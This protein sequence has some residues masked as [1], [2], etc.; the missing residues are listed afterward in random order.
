MELTGMLENASRLAR[1]MRPCGVRVFHAPITFA[2]D[3]SDNPNRNLGILAGC[4]NERLFTRH[5]LK[6]RMDVQ[7]HDKY[8]VTIPSGINLPL[9]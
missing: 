6:V 8:R 5:G 3:G 9:T 7:S 4:D 1:D 2:P